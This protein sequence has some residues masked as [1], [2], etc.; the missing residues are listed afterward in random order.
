MGN[1]ALASGPKL[2]RPSSTLPLA[3]DAFPVFHGE[4]LEGKRTRPRHRLTLT[5]SLKGN[6]RFFTKR[7]FRNVYAGNS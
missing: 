3:P 7:T 1:G 4:K 5:S 2:P 6:V